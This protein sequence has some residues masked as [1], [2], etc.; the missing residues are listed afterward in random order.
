MRK[1]LSPDHL[2]SFIDGRRYKS[3]NRDLISNGL[4]PGAYRTRY[5][6]TNDYP[7]IAPRYSDQLS[8]L[9]RSRGLGGRRAAPQPTPA[10]LAAPKDETFT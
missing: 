7:M 9:S 2:T 10:P 3:L 6:L 1:S 5:G 4:T 8:A